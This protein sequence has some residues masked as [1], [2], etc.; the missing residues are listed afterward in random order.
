LFLLWS[1]P[2][3][4]FDPGA[5]MSFAVSAA[6]LW[7]CFPASATDGRDWGGFAAVPVLGPVVNGLH[8]CFRV[9]LVALAASAPITAQTFGTVAPMAALWNLIAVPLTGF[10]LLPGALLLSAGVATLTGLGS[11]DISMLCAQWT[12]WVEGIWG[13]SLDLALMLAPTSPLL[14]T[15]TQVPW[16]WM[17]AALGLAVVTARVK[18]TRW[19]TL[20]AGLSCAVLSGAPVT[21][22]TPEP[23]RIA[24]LDVG[25]GDAILI[26]GREAAVLIDA[27]NS[28]ITGGSIGEFI[29]LPA[30]H[31]MKVS[32]LDLL[33][34]SHADRDHQGGLAAVLRGMSVGA[35]WLP[36]G[37][38]EDPAFAELSQT[39]H[40]RGIW[41]ERVSENF[42]AAGAA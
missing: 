15:N 1:E 30:L 4:L 34:A 42:F 14:M 10:V 38:M 5:Q 12:P 35:L 32:H 17:G 41:S 20:S 3:L 2:Q 29:V 33:V 27:G 8:S 11:V 25:Q 36:Y 31:A 21:S 6:L 24:F 37:G 22:I 26:Q 7:M 9:S 16:P 23:P 40:D 39:A 28:F 13:R 18:H 19:K